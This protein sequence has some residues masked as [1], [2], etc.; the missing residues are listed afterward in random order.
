VQLDLPL[1]DG[2]NAHLRLSNAALTIGLGMNLVYTFD[3]SGRLFGAFREGRNLRRG[4]DGRVLARWRDNQRRR[5]RIWLSEAECKRLLEDVRRDLERILAAEPPTAYAS[6]LQRART[7]DYDEDVLRFRQVYRPIS[8]LPPDQYQAL[9]L[10]ATEGCSF[11]TCI[12][13]ALYRDREFRIK[14][15]AGFAA[16]IQ[17]VKGLLREGVRLRRSI[18]LADANALVIP[19]ERLL[20]LFAEI[21][22]AFEIMPHTVSAAQRSAWLQTHPNG[23]T[24]VFA[25]VDGLSAERKSVEDFRT[26]RERGLR[27]VYIGLESGHEPLLAW[28]RKPSTAAEMLDAVKRMKQAGLH[29]G[30]IVL[31]GVGGRRFHEGH[32]HD[33]AAILNAMPLGRDDIIYLSPFQPD[34]LAPYLEIAQAE[35]IEPPDPE[36][37]REQNRLIR[38][39]LTLPPPPAGPK[40][41]PYNLSDFVY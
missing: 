19:Q 40:R 38:A 7:F 9:V 31:T 37:A 10:Q 17:A 39:L 15:P 1:G 27:R 29:I 20:P 30:V 25:F 4:L 22:R 23:V 21:A 18:F 3:L 5:R 36:F 24:G 34:P 11:N 41:A 32:C 12:F 28:L 26:L 6:V 2:D 33:T 8:I 35:G 13:C 16:H 14:S